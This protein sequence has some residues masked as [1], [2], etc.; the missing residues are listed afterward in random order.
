MKATVQIII[1]ADKVDQEN[2][3]WLFRTDKERSEICGING[4]ATQEFMDFLKEHYKKEI[5]D[6]I[7]NEHDYEI[8]YI[9]DEHAE[10]IDF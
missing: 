6:N 9:Y 3:L 5:Y 8:L 1:F 4:S 10:I 7:S 2:E